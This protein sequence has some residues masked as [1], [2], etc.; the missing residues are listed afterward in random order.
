[1][2]ESASEIIFSN[3]N[4]Y[5]ALACDKHVKVFHNITGRRVAINDLETSL[6]TAK[7]QGAKERFQSLIDEHRFIYFILCFLVIFISF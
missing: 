6:K 7:T 3:D 4:K 1:M 5:L 2:E